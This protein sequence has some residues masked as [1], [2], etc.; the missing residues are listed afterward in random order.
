MTGYKDSVVGA[1]TGDK[2]QQTSGAYHNLSSHN[3]R[4]LKLNVPFVG[5]VQ[6]EA[7]KAQ[8]EANKPL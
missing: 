8:Q 2:T 6:K 4:C 7:G 5:N 1:I 3:R